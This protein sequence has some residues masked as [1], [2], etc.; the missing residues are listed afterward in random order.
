MRKSYFCF[1]LL[2]AN[3]MQLNHKTA[4][5][6]QTL[7]KFSFEVFQVDI[8]TFPDKNPVSVHLVNI[9]RSIL[10][11]ITTLGLIVDNL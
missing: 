8:S 11:F 2:N 3:L 10:G 9:S 4:V 6:E 5:S 1:L 7:F